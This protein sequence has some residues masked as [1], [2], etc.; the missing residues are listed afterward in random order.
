LQHLSDSRYKEWPLQPKNVLFAVSLRDRSSENRCHRGLATRRQA[1][2]VMKALAEYDISG[3]LAGV[4]ASV[5]QLFHDGSIA[6]TGI[7]RAKGNEAP[8]V[9]LLNSE[10]TTLLP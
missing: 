7:Y 8:M 3:H 4:M 5:D 9:Y 6:I 1:A 10:Y 2:I